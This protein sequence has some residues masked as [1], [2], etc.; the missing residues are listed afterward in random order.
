MKLFVDTS[1]TRMLEVILRRLSSEVKNT[2]RQETTS[3]DLPK[4]TAHRDRVL[5]RR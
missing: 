2:S 3:D 5:E 4:A 1:Y